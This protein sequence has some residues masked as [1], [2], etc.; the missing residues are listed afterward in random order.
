[1]IKHS[2]RQKFKVYNNLG[3]KW[4]IQVTIHTW[5]L[6]WVPILTYETLVTAVYHDNSGT[7]S[8]LREHKGV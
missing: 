5:S 4:N 8:K 2:I 3:I 7:L 6:F 1:M